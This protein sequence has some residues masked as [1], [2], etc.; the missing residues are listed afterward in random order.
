MEEEDHIKQYTIP[1]S[2]Y[3]IIFI[4]LHIC[5]RNMKKYQILVKNKIQTIKLLD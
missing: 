3:V 4:F 2:N 1:P 5:K